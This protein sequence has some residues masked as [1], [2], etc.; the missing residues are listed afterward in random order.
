MNKEHQI[1]LVEELIDVSYK[2]FIRK[3]GNG[4]ITA[5]NEASFQLEFGHILKTIGNLYEFTLDDKFHLELETT[6]T[7]KTKSIKSKSL[8]ARIDLYIHYKNESSKTNAAIE[9][10]FFKKKNHREP[11]NRYDVF[12]DL[13][14]LELYKKEDDIDLCYFILGTDHEHYCYQEVYSK[15]TEDFD[16]R[17]GKKYPAK[18]NL[19]YKTPQPYGD[20]IYLENDYEFNWDTIQN[21]HFLKVKI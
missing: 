4:S 1:N 9:L 12:K 6:K 3:L 2:I 11:N 14:N 10:K 19:K 16:F 8:K 20:D 15:D 21:L 17:N 7:L 13:S 5:L 18:K